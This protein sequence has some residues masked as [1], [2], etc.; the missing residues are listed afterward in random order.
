[1][2]ASFLLQTAVGFDQATLLQQ[3]AAHRDADSV[4]FTFLQE[5]SW[6]MRLTIM[7]RRSEMMTARALAKMLAAMQKGSRK[8]EY[9]VW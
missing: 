3:F 6:P 1:M 4:A 9:V 7:K 8:S 5:S 2:N